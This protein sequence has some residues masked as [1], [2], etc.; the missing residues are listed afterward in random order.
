MNGK[1]NCTNPFYFLISRIKLKMPL[2]SPISCCFGKTVLNCELIIWTLNSWQR[3][4]LVIKHINMMKGQR[5]FLITW[6]EVTEK[7]INY[8]TWQQV[9][10]EWF[11]TKKGNKTITFSK[12]FYCKVQLFFLLSQ[13]TWKGEDF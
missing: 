8:I 3:H 13:S 9:H 10:F 6:L 11:K 4:F 12:D 7:L 5:G 2:R 1:E